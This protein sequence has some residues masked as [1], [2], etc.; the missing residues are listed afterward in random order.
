MLAMTSITIAATLASS[1]QT[2]VAV[3]LVSY[4]KTLEIRELPP[5]ILLSLEIH[6][7]G[8]FFDRQTH[9]QRSK[10]THI[11]VYLDNAGRRACAMGHGL[12]LRKRWR[13]REMVHKLT[14]AQ[15]WGMR[16]AGSPRLSSCEIGTAC[17]NGLE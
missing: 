1:V 15:S 13:D 12:Q 9:L 4:F 7:G 17:L 8:Y 10:H 14:I 3:K 6:I 2:T 16:H 5:P 11:S